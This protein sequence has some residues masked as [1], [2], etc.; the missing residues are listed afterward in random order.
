MNHEQVSKLENLEI[1]RS[2]LADWGTIDIGI[3]DT[4]IPD[5]GSRS[6]QSGI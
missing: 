6:F 5:L 1:K 3:I 4:E 2:D